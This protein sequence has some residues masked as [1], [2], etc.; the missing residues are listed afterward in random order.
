MLGR[1]VQTVDPQQ[2]EESMESYAV[3]VEGNYNQ[4]EK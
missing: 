2:L 3:W 1:I 4:F